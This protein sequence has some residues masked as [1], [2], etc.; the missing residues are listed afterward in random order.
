MAE[1]TEVPGIGPNVAKQMR[2]EG[3]ESVTDVLEASTGELTDVKGIGEARAD[4]LKDSARE[5]A[6]N[7]VDGDE[8]VASHYNPHTNETEEDMEY[9]CDECGK[10]PWNNRAPRDAHEMNCDG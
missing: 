9:Y 1:L 10:G 5:F 7:E 3:F 8:V 4:D 6:K 2:D